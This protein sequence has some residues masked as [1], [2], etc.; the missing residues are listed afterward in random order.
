VH[1]RVLPI[2]LP[3]FAKRKQRQ[4]LMKFIAVVPARLESQR[5]PRKMLR[6]IGGKPLAV[7]VYQAV[8]KSPLLQ[9]V[10]IATDSEEILEACRKHSCNARMTSTKHRSGTE[11]VHEVSQSVEAD[12]YINVQGDEPMI[13]AAHIE[14]LVGLMKDVSA[15]VGTLMT[16]ASP[17]DISSPSAVK[18]VTDMNGRA[19]YFSRSTIPY[20]RDGLHPRYFKHLGI[21]AYRKAVLDRF[22]SLSESALERAERL[23]QLRFLENGIP[24]FAAET[25]YDSIG[26]D[27]E[28]D[29]NRV[30]SLLTDRK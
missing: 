27:T 29:L 5:L 4:N 14:A 28:E 30:V 1:R 16:P 24:I 6:E 3:R 7:W 2:H 22:V 21:Y 12:V 26:V 18:V 25:P 10:I 11:R 17:E 23:E 13:R 8:R 15:P 19:L 9:D 20:D